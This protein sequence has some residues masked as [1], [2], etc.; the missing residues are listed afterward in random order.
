MWLVTG[1][2]LDALHV[3]PVTYWRP[4]NLKRGNRVCATSGGRRSQRTI[5]PEERA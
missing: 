4:T 5:I 3:A 1:F 2:D